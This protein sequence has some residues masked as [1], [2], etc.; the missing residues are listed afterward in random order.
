MPKVRRKTGNR[1]A[2]S[3]VAGAD[4]RV[5]VVLLVVLSVA[6]FAAR[7]W[8]GVALSAALL[9]G[10]LALSRVSGRDVARGVRPTAVV[11]AF[12]LLANA[13]L[14][15][16]GGVAFSYEGALRGVLA[17]CRIVVVVGFAL[18]VAATT[19][20]PQVADAV[21]A[22]IRPLG[23]LS[24]PV[25]DVSMAT[26]VALRFIPVVSQELDRVSAAQ[27]ARGARLGE[28]GLAVRMAQWGQVLV[29]VVVGLFRRSDELALALYDR[30]YGQAVRTPMLPALSARAWAELALGLG[31]AALVW[32]V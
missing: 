23:R 3:P 22:L 19:S 18:V 32:L 1:S 6:V 16:P 9:V 31:F 20:S 4:A 15:T 24:L 27:R 2:E 14:A 28:G 5:K 29:P 7:S 8:R 25:G 12:A 10:L 11:L 21:G 30:C 17:V 26:S 13:L